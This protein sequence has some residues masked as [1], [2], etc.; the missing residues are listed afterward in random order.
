MEQENQEQVHSFEEMIDKFSNNEKPKARGLSDK[1]SK[2]NQALYND[3]FFD[4]IQNIPDANKYKLYHLIARSSM[5]EEMLDYPLDTGD[6]AYEN[7]INNIEHYI[8][9]GLKAA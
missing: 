2:H 5:N 9:E 1:L 6:G 3:P 4:Y 7:F 8:E